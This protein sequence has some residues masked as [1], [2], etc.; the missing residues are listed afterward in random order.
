MA[1]QILVLD[2]AGQPLRWGSYEDAIVYHA[3]G[4]VAWQLGDES[5]TT[6]RGG[7]NSLTGEQ[8]SITTAPIIAVRGEVGSKRKYKAPALT[9]R[10]LFARDRWTCAYCC[11]VSTEAKLTR[12]HVLPV[13]RGGKD[14]WEN[15][16][17]SCGKCNNK[18]DNFLLTEVKMELQYY[19][20]VPS[21][22]DVLFMKARGILPCQA[23]YLLPFCS[24]RARLS[25]EGIL[26]QTGAAIEF[27]HKS[28]S[29]A[30]PIRPRK[31]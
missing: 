2:N 6:F 7:V 27:L 25:F 24:D 20:Y 10:D 16:V 14:I 29:E 1:R 15:V 31:K 5:H 3:K 21:R 28:F 9:N 12:D 18:K 4:L 13:S 19:P 11:V 22:A 23:E 17:T 26:N 30:Q 8:S